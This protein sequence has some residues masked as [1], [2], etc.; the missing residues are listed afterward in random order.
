MFADMCGGCSRR[1]AAVAFLELLQLKTAGLLRLQQPDGPF[2]NIQV[3]ADV[4]MF[5]SAVLLDF[6]LCD[7][8]FMMISFFGLV[9]NSGKAVEVISI[10][11]ISDADSLRSIRCISSFCVC[12]DKLVFCKVFLYFSE[13][14]LL[15]IQL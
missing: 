3:T 12:F 15:T 4:C 13:Y 10:L 7:S 1:T 6:F 9:S 14:T 5:V 8:I 11:L 2:A